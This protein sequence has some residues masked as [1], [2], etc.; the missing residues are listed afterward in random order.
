MD[1]ERIV[2]RLSAIIENRFGCALRFF[3]VSSIEKIKDSTLAQAISRNETAPFIVSGSDLVLPIRSGHGLLGAAVVLSG[4]ALGSEE[5]DQVRQVVDLILG[6]YLVQ[7]EKLDVLKSVQTLLETQL[8]PE[9]VVSM[10]QSRPLFPFAEGTPV[11]TSTIEEDHGLPL[12]IEGQSASGLR[13]IAL[14]VH[15]SSGRNAFLSLDMVNI[16]HVNTVEGLGQM[17]RITL[18][19]AEVG[20]LTMAQQNLFSEY[21]K[22]TRRYDDCPRLIFATELAVQEL[23]EVRGISETF[24][25]EISVARIQLT[26]E[27]SERL[28]KNPDIIDFLEHKRRAQMSTIKPQDLH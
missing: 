8:L 6:S 21:V 27:T 2:N 4:S 25:K 23:V 19:I 13:D 24:L 12:L 17:G 9:N 26:T 5:M 14:K 15:N 16:D 7:S 1:S 11:I 3:D 22:Q 10:A 28:H 20:N 18:F